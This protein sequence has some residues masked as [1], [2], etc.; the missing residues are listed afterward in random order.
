MS[1]TAGRDV[2]DPIPPNA[3][4]SWSGWLYGLLVIVLGWVGEW[5]RSR[6]QKP[7]PPPPREHHRADDDCECDHHHHHRASDED[8]EG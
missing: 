7:P 3:N 5:L 6:W 2:A 8:E 1:S 4:G